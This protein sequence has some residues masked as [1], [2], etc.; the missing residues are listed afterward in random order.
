MP[1]AITATTATAAAAAATPA[2][3]TV[4]TATTRRAFFAGTS[5]IDGQGATLEIL[6]ME[7]RDGFGRILLRS[8]FDEGESAGA[9]GGAVL[10]D[11]DSND[12]T[13]LGEVVL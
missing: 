10:H 2:T 9:T 3:T 8:H 5:L 4:A 1:V 11:V 13:R 12:R 7:H 6:L